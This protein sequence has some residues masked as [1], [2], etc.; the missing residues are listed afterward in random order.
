MRNYEVMTIYNIDLGEESA[1]KTSEEVQ[2]LIKSLG[3]NVVNVDFWGKRKFAYEI[4]HQEEGYYD[5]IKFDLSGDNIEVLKKKLNLMSSVIRYLI[6][7][8]D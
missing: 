5:V 4:N 3:G 8:L 6:T 7:A 2:N 1:K